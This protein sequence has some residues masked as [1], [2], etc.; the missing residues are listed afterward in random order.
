M[1]H[2]CFFDGSQYDQLWNFEP[3]RP[4]G[5]EPDVN[6]RITENCPELAA[7][8]TRMALAEYGAMLNHWRNPALD[9]DTWIGFT[10]YRQLT[11][12]PTIFRSKSEV[13]S[14]LQRG[15][16]VCWHMWHMANVRIGWITGAAA[17][18]EIA[19]PGIHQFTK[20]M[21]AHFRTALPADYM[22]ATEIPLANYWA[23][24]RE[25]F[26]DFMAWSWPIVAH[27]LTSNHRYLTTASS[28]NAMDNKHRAV[29][30]FMERLFV[31]WTLIRK[32]QPVV[33]GP[34]YDLGGK[35]IEAVLNLVPVSHF[36]T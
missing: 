23:M 16:Y 21:L 29:G 24:R 25:R 18:A 30:Y 5:L 26:E 33:V 6:D 14:L 20:D 28:V 1:I 22:T 17:Q 36:S 15:D 8:E 27:S 13:E 7:A 10:S 11:K 12:S 9:S 31:I 3:Y 19:H 2:Q 32:L 34:R 4:F 35:P